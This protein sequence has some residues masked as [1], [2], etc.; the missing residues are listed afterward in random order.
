MGD[1][2]ARIVPESSRTQPGAG[3]RP[4]PSWA[5][6]AGTAR[7]RSSRA[8]VV[9]ASAV[10]C[11]SK[12][13]T[14]LSISGVERPRRPAAE[15]GGGGG[16]SATRGGGGG[17]G[18]GTLRSIAEGGVAAVGVED[19]GTSWG[20]PSR[21]NLDRADRD[22]ERQLAEGP[23]R[24]VAVVARARAARRAADAGDQA[25]RRRR[26]GRTSSATP[27]TS[28]RTTARAAGTASPS[29]A[30]A[31]IDDVVTNF[32]E[33]LRP[34]RTAGRRRR[35]AARRGAHDLGR[36]AAASA[37]CR[38]Y[39][40]N[41][42]IVGSV[43]YQAKLAWFDRL[44]RWLAEAA[45]PRDAARARAATST[46]RPPTPTS[47]T[48]AACHGGTHV[49]EPEREAFARLCRLGA[50][51]R[52]P[53]PAPRAGALHLVGLPRRQLPQELRHAHRPPARHARRSPSASSGPRSTARRAR[54]S[55]SRPTTR[56]SSSTS[57]SRG[58]PST[59]AGPRPR[60]ASP[61]GAAR[62]LT[63]SRS[64]RRS[65]R[66]WRSSRSELPDGDGWLFEPK[67]DGFRAHRLPRR[68]AASTSR[69]AT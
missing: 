14:I 34:P 43:F 67:W 52:L 51:R 40:P 15:G 2:A 31:G 36:R 69:A 25:R 20:G 12:R 47:G 58:A 57:T 33:P 26:A 8:S 41:G 63:A 55:P 29:P 28:S 4:P 13:P 30:A 60:S 27:A 22:L 49:S 19:L 10:D 42:R 61:R 1:G 64:S 16:G 24:K 11:A 5:G 7:S 46:S 18:R 6:D 65:S 3:G 35:R 68:R 50:R 32:G 44:A 21:G 9:P 39:A 37:S 23:P 45:D 54:A 17:E 62:G 56:R 48:R 38:V 53:A 59:P 66:C